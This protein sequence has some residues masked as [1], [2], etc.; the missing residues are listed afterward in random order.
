MAAAGNP[1]VGAG[2]V[3]SGGG[4]LALG[5]GATGVGDVLLVGWGDGVA[6]TPNTDPLGA[7]DGEPPA[8]ETGLGVAVGRGLCVGADVGLGVGVADGPFSVEPGWKQCA[9]PQVSG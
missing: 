4:A 6:A 7:G 8:P 2:D 5:V 1:P 9:L 3:A